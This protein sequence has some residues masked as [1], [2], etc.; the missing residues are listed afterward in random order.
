MG[1]G[2]QTLYYEHEG[3]YNPLRFCVMSMVLREIITGGPW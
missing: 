2:D 3:E 1:K